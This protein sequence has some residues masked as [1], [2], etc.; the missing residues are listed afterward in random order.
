M[1]VT[2]QRWCLLVLATWLLVGVVVTVLGFAG[3]IYEYA[4]FL[5]LLPVTVLFLVGLEIC[6]S[7]FR[8]F[9]LEKALLLTLTG[10]WLIH[11]TGIFVPETGFDAVWYHLPIAHEITE[12]HR[13]V[14]LPDLYQSLNPLF[15][16]LLFVLGYQVAGVM[17]AKGVAF[18]LGLTLVLCTYSLARLFLIREWSLWLA[19]IVS[20]FQVVTW[21]STSFYVDVGKA[22]WEVAALWLL[23]SIQKKSLGLSNNYMWLLIGA[24]V[25][26]SLATKAFSVLLLPVFVMLIL[27][28]AKQSK[29]KAVL[30]SS[31][32]AL[33]VSLPF[34]ARTWFYSGNVFL[35][36]SLHLTKLEEIGGEA[37]VVTYV[38]QRLTQLPLSLFHLTW[39]ITDYVTILFLVLLPLL[40]WMI[41]HERRNQEILGLL[42]FSLSQWLLWW[43]V[44][45]LST[46]YALSGFIVL[47]L[48]TL[49]SVRNWL[50]SNPSYRSAIIAVLVMAV[51]I[52]LVPRVYVLRRNLQ[53]VLGNQTQIEYFQQ[54]KDGNIDTHL[55]KWYHLTSF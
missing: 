15:T 9:S 3:Y 6:Q 17:G 30:L 27:M 52:N 24:C 10:V 45:P 22:V 54:F 14:F 7:F 26:A 44:P 12:A 34:Y 40:G 4:S 20:T 41:W 31:V 53:Y 47:S 35:S 48:L 29:L 8:L 46:R 32:A 13:L 18:L 21:Q 39:G 42:L 23:F 49:I 33:I 36:P 19:L 5:L 37:N 1:K 38:G 28:Q 43:F 2:F 50:R 11:S 55:Q 25:G 51:G 16:D